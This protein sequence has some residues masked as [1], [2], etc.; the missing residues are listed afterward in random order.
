VLALS[1]AW[2]CVA[3]LLIAPAAFFRFLEESIPGAKLVVIKGGP[4]GILASHPKEVNLALLSFLA[5]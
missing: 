2:A 4:H 5:S 1:A 3:T